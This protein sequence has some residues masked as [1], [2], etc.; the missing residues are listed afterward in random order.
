MLPSCKKAL[1]ALS[2]SVL[3]ASENRPV[4]LIVAVL[5]DAGCAE[6]AREPESQS[7]LANRWTSP[8]SQSI[9]KHEYVD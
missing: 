9:Q 8:K 4:P 1:K 3:K 6:M 5:M 7:T 2:L